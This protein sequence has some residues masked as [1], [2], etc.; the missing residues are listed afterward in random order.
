MDVQDIGCDFFTFSGHKMLA[1]LG[2][3]VLF[4]RKSLLQDMSPFLSGGGMIRSVSRD[5]VDWNDLPW[6]FE[7]GTPDACG[8]VAL[9]GAIDPVT[10]ERLMGAIDYLEEVGMGAIHNHE[11]DLC[12]YVIARFREL[13]GIVTYGPQDAELKCG[14]V[15]FN[16]AKDGNLVHSQIIANF[17]NDSGI[18]FRSGG[19]C[20]YPLFKHIGVEGSVRASFYLYNTREEIDRMT[21]E[22]AAIISRKLL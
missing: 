10:G 11:R 8:A 14:I 2:I 15:S 6:K 12:N 7:A 4:G 17:L 13:E 19:H 18:L 3:G 5:P 22:L 9:G 20:A 16:I 1:P 21:E